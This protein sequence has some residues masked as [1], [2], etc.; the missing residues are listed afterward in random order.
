ME[1]TQKQGKKKHFTKVNEYSDAI[2][3]TDSEK[4]LR[5]DIEKDM[6]DLDD[7]EEDE[8]GHDEKKEDISDGGAESD[9]IATE[10]AP[11]IENGKFEG[12][13]GREEPKVLL[14]QCKGKRRVH[15]RQV[16]V[17][18]KSLNLG[19]VFVLIDNEHEVVYLWHGAK[20]NRMLKM[21]GWDVATRVNRKQYGGR[22]KMEKI[23]SSKEPEE[24]WETLGGEGDIAPADKPNVETKKLKQ[25]EQ[26][27]K[28]YY[29]SVEKGKLLTLKGKPN[30][31]V[32]KPDRAFVLDCTSEIY[33]WAGSKAPQ[34]MID[35]G[36]EFAMKLFRTKER[37]KWTTIR[38]VRQSEEPVLFVEKLTTDKSRRKPTGGNRN[39]FKTL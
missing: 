35:K 14:I 18:H 24:F 10:D 25:F 12:P 22:C 13:E 15:V 11:D 29:V 19:D 1:M 27:D 30:V 5:I 3:E 28:L 26:Q 8:N 38:E 23:T 21:K 33:V 7:K 37:P 20:V 32:L 4:M 2:T 34:E 16:E 6:E 39:N 17:S 9:D 36:K 31:N